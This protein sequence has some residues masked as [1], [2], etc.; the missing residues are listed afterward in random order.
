MI[1]RKKK[2]VAT[3]DVTNES[4]GRWLRAGKPPFEWF[5]LLDATTQEQLAILG[6]QWVT[7]VALI[8]AHAIRDPQA[9]EAAA[10]AVLGDEKAQVDLI[11]RLAGKA[12]ANI[13]E[14]DQKAKPAAPAGPSMAGLFAGRKQRER[15]TEPRHGTFLGEPTR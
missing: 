12:V 5:L 9:A 10:G 13:L 7:E 3:V 2:T 8:A 4:Y 11:Q 1:W 14:R 15:T 6:D